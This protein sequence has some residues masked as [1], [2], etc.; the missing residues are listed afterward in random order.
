MKATALRQLLLLLPLL[1]WFNQSQ[2]E[3]PSGATQFL[4]NIVKFVEGECRIPGYRQPYGPRDPRCG[5][6][7]YQSGR[8]LSLT[9]GTGPGPEQNSC[10]ALVPNVGD[11][12]FPPNVAIPIYQAPDNGNATV[13]QEYRDF[14]TVTIQNSQFNGFQSY[15][16]FQSCGDIL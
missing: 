10:R 15:Q 14:G 12:G 8:C 4:E 2:P 11:T 7:T 3:A 13:C 1:L 16:W 5:I 6:S 9:K